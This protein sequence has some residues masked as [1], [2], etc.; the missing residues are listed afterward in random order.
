MTEGLSSH[1]LCRKGEL[2]CGEC[3]HN[4][5]SLPRLSPTE[6]GSPCSGWPVPLRRFLRA[7]VLEWPMAGLSVDKGLLDPEP[8]WG[9]GHFL[10]V[11]GTGRRTPLSLE[12]RVSFPGVRSRDRRALCFCE[13]L[14]VASTQHPTPGVA[15]AAVSSEGSTATPPLSRR[16]PGSPPFFT[17]WLIPPQ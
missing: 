17:T 3:Q 14:S 10:A 2:A 8:E 12:S 13:G 9:A 15:G 1:V 6:P 11:L 4:D 5:L 7:L 16:G